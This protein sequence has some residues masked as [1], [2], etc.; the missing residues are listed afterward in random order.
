[1]TS[2]ILVTGGTGTLGR[3]VVRC[4][5][6][7]GR[8]VRVLS[9]GSHAPADRTEYVTGDLATGEGVPAAVDGTPVIVHCAGSGS[10]DEVTTRN[11]AQAAARAGARHLVY[12]SVVGASRIPVAS[13]TDRMMFGYFASKAAAEQEVAGSGLPWTTL[14]ATQFYDLILLVVRQMAKLPVIP[15]PAG[16]RFQ[17]VDSGE[18]AAALAELALGRPAGLVPDLAGPRV[19]SV[20]ELLRGYLRARGRHR[21]LVPVRLPGKAARAVR[22]GANLA[23]DRA[24]GQ[25]T[26]EDFL[27]ERVPGAAPAAGRA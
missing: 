19:Y 6:D 10:G 8:E 27:A 1:M 14:R 20:P 12:I 21:P 3:Q 23:P 18:V 24:V 13:R 22:A 11:L 15:V 2:P 9:R 5:L 26:W 4:L 16:F 7:A 17:P 25:R